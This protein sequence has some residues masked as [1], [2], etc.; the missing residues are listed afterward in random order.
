MFTDPALSA[1]GGSVIAT[2]E[3]SFSETPMLMVYPTVAHRIVM[4]VSGG[5]ANGLY[6]SDDPVYSWSMNGYLDPVITIDPAYASRFSLVQSDIP[7]VPVPEM[8]TWLLMLVGLC[9]M[10]GLVRRRSAAA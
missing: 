8:S 5:V 2:G 10:A 3:A 9:A 6:N 7:M 4:Q 1:P